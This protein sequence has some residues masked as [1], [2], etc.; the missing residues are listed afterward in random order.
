LHPEQNIGWRK[1][2]LEHLHALFGRA[3]KMNKHKS[4]Y[5]M[6]KHQQICVGI[7]V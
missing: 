2:R 5:V 7:F 6:T 1:K 3:V 4:I